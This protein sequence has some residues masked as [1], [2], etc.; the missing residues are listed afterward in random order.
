MSAVLPP[1]LPPILPTEAILPPRPGKSRAFR[2]TGMCCVEEVRTLKAAVG[3]LAGGDEGLGFDLL[4][5]KMTVPAD[6]DA[7]KVIAAIARTGMRAE[8]WERT[9]VAERD[10]ANSSRRLLQAVLAGLSGGAALLGLILDQAFHAVLPAQIMQAVA[11]AVGLWMVLPKALHAVRSLRP[12]MNLLM[13]VAVFGA[14]ALG[15]WMEAATVSALFALSLALES[16]SAERA[17]R[18]IASLMDLTPPMA[19]VKGGDGVESLAA[20][21][22]VPVGAVFVVLPGERIPLDGRVLVGESMVDQAPITG[23]SVPVLKSVGTEVFAG[24]INADG[25]LEV[26]NLKPAGETT[27]AKVA[28]LVEE[29]QGRRSKVERWVDRF[30]AIYT[31]VVLAGAVAVAVLPPLALGLDWFEWIYRSLVLLVISCPCALVI[32]TPLTVVAAMASAARAGVLVKG[33]EY[34]ETASRLSAIAFDKTGTVTSGRPGVERVMALD[35]G[36]EGHILR[37]AAALEARSTHPLGRAIL[38]HAAAGGIV[39]IPAEAAQ[40]LPGK[41]ICGVVDGETVWL[42]SHRYAVERGAET[43]A[44]REAA[45]ALAEGG[46]SV[47]VVGDGAEVR[48]LIALSDPIRPEAATALAALRQAGV[49]KLIMLTGDNAATGERVAAALGFDLVLAE[50]LPEDKS[51]AMDDLARQFGTVAMV[52]DGVNDAPAMTRSSLGI[53]MGAAGTDTAIETSD[54]AL[55]SDDLTRLAWLIGHSRRMMTVIRQNIG[56][57]IAL[58]VVFMV[59]AIL[60]IATLWG[61]IA[62][63]MGAALLVAFNGLRLLKATATPRIDGGICLSVGGRPVADRGS[64]ASG[65][66]SIF[67]LP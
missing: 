2:I 55:M 64:K 12:D 62:A 4:N 59:L 38:D 44:V 18:A 16:W 27:L 1:V 54:M 31:P 25:V 52:G 28:R 43:P 67:G 13:S 10:K 22:D 42:G 6:M 39:T 51:E 33:G 29:A 65:S 50:L 57:A 41:G 37:L 40:A 35:G 9:S 45:L 15:D 49:R 19:R 48:G 20:P 56:F 23:E 63:D 58:K 26:R 8:P 21:E 53:A 34:L 14:M 11:V 17:R 60:D 30:A 61:A 46:R 47:V 3:P 5:G 66:G 36:D 24:T 32:S 7:H